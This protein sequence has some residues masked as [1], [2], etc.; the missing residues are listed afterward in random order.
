ME[1]G[2][3]GRRHCLWRGW[4]PRLQSRAEHW[5]RRAGDRQEYGAVATKAG[6]V[7]VNGASVGGV[8]RLARQVLRLFLA[9]A[10]GLAVNQ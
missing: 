8:A 6:K 3:G 7:R 1:D 5:T 10:N 9:K 4:Q 2:G